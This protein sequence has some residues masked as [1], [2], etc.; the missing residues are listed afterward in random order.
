MKRKKNQVAGGEWWIQ[1]DGFTMYADGDI[2]DQ[3]HAMA[4]YATI[5]SEYDIDPEREEYMP[6]LVPYSPLDASDTA[7]FRKRGVKGAVLKLLKDGDDPREWMIEHRGWI[8]L[9]GANAELWKF[10][11]ATLDSLRSGIWEAWD[12][13][14]WDDMDPEEL[15]F[16]VTIEEAKTR[17]TFAV[18]LKALMDDRMDVESLKRLGAEGE[19]VQAPSAPALRAAWAR[20]AA[21]ERGLENPKK[22]RSLAERWLRAKVQLDRARLKGHRARIMTCMK[23]LD[24]IEEQMGEEGMER[25]WRQYGGDRGLENP[26]VAP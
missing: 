7:W 26:T 6:V 3:N 14:A 15:D 2:G 17:R 12:G 19:I 11:A 9:A 22:A 24:A 10:D 20:R 16:D 18:P 1:D 21:H 25:T 13:D 4:A 5:L 23:R 8:R